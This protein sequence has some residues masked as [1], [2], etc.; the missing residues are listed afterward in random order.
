MVDLFEITVPKRERLKKYLLS[1]L[2]T[3]TSDVIAWGQDNFFNRAEREARDLA[4]EGLI[5]RLT[6]QEKIFYGFRTKED[7][8]TNLPKSI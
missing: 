6:D 5:R 2:Y 8:W 7:I 4:E 3:K 1:R